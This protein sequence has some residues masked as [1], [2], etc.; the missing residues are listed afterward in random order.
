MSSS[1]DSSTDRLGEPQRFVLPR[2]HDRDVA[3]QGWLLECADETHHTG[4]SRVQNAGVKVCIYFTKGES[5]VVQIVRWATRSDGTSHERSNVTVHARNNWGDVVETL[6]KDN[7]GRLGS[8]SKEA[9]VRACG[10][11]PK[12]KRYAY[13]E[14]E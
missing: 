2:D 4:N 13:E 9:W 14:I 11:H 1:P 8:L 12:L 7:S 6:K 3:F 5:V 10:K